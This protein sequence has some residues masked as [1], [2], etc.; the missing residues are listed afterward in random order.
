MTFPRTGLTLASLVSIALLFAAAAPAWA[1]AQAAGE[2]VIIAA[3]LTLTGEG[4]SFGQPTLEGIQFAVEEAMAADPSLRLKVEPFDDAGDD[5]KARAAAEQVVAS[6]AVVALGPSFSTASLAAGPVYAA[7]GVAS[8]PPTATSDAITD[9]PTTFRVVFKNSDQGELLAQYLVRVLDRH[10]ASVVVI[11]SSYGATLKD[12]F[13]RT[14]ALLNL[15]AHYHLLP[16][17]ADEAALDAIVSEVAAEH[18][19]VVLLTLDPEGKRLLL[20]LRRLGHQG[21]FL[22]GDSF[23]Q[24]EFARLFA[25]EPEELQ[26]PGFFTDGLYGLT[27]V[28]FDSANAEILAF[29]RRF[30]ARFG[31]EPI[32]DTAAGYDAAKIAID[33]IRAALPGAPDQPG[34][35][36]V[37][38]RQ[39]LLSLDGPERAR[40]A[41]LGPFWF[42]NGRAR[43][44]AIR[45]GRFHGGR[46]ESAPL[47]IVAVSN[48]ATS[49]VAS[50]AVFDMGAGH[51]G[52]L[53]RV[54]YTGVYLNEIQRI[55]V[56]RESFAADLYL[57]LRFAK[58][59][60]PGAA[61]PTDILF[62]TQIGG[63]F[64]RSRPSERRERADGTEYWLWRVQGEFRNDFD[65]RRFPFDR[66]TLRLPFFNARAA[67]D[68]IVYAIDRESPDADGG[69]ARPIASTDAF[70][71]ITQWQFTGAGQR[72][73][74]L[75]TQS[76]LGDLDR[77]AA[78]GGRELSGFLAIFDLRRQSLTTL[79]KTLLPMLLMSTI[80][81]AS[82]FFP[83]ALVKEKV[84]VA[85]T[86]ALSGAVLLSSINGQ[87]GNIG[88]TVTVEYVFYAF[89]ALALLCIVS[90]LAVERLRTA[91]RNKAA[92]GVE[93]G[94][95]VIYAA[96]TAASLI[97]IAVLSA[98]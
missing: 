47:Q 11:D 80:T 17:N 75:V 45:V 32:W 10:A 91:K 7:G 53:Q 58:D 37:K 8:L 62:P 31:H 79:L 70:R 36:R 2:P 74:N 78:E 86:G 20:R 24:E 96:A 44:Q 34:L 90:V 42:D 35:Q 48:P 55:D 72:R 83:A 85:I 6:K 87:L 84:T 73:E 77:T 25:G 14:A 13:E 26:Q 16:R 68:R 89:F 23:G 97:A 88:Y 46:F 19:P 82:L 67:N 41:L 5:D 59:A 61:D 27:P 71:N 76:G 69:D 57:W 56:A 12:G 1:Q 94:T 40:P 63:G 49:E 22:G 52:R 50:G 98:P 33:A 95:R 15:D 30:R 51:Y 39:Y 66:Q 29:A 28:I 9:S 92:A 93:L 3:P 64:D 4:V 65:L 54:V 60:G 38:V 43:Q 18:L 21:P 81:F